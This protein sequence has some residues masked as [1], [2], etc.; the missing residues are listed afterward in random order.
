MIAKGSASSTG[1]IWM[2]FAVRVRNHQEAV[3]DFHDK[4]IFIPT[5]SLCWPSALRN[6][7]PIAWETSL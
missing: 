7:S 4:P 3:I 2:Y 5:N 1:D 6:L